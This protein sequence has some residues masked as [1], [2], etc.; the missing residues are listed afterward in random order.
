MGAMK[1]EFLENLIIRDFPVTVNFMTF[2]SVGGPLSRKNLK[3]SCAHFP[4]L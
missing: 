1:K 2:L 3:R 4:I